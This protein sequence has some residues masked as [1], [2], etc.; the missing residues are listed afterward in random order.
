MRRLDDYPGIAFPFFDEDHKVL[1]VAGKGESA[2]TY[3]QFSKSGNYLELLSAF[4]GKEPQKGFSM[5]PKK[6]V[7]PIESEV[8]RGVR[9]TAKTVEYVH[10]KVPRKT[11]GFTK[12]LFPDWRVGT[13]AHEFASYWSGVDKEPVREVVNPNQTAAGEKKVNFLS[14]LTGAPEHEAAKPAQ[15]KAPAVADNSAAIIA[16]KDKEIAELK[17]QIEALK[18]QLE[19]TET[20]AQELAERHAQQI[21]ELYAAP[22]PEAQEG[23]LEQ[24][25]EEAPAAE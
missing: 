1:Y 18:T 16:A 19:E 13:P 9:M 3:Y 15:A 8:M 5:M 25:Y 20:A 12:D 7:D 24:A 22:A 14:K 2:I 23:L 10:F 21:A 11:G 4:K 17:A 6:C